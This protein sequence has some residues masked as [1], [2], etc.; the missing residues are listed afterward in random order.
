MLATRR[1][2]GRKTAAIAESSMALGEPAIP[3][4]LSTVHHGRPEA[5]RRPVG[6]ERRENANT[7]PSE[8]C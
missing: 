3:T 4:A 6:N 2:R 1:A 8:R 7:W 5:Q